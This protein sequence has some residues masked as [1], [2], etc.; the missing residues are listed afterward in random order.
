MKGCK[1]ATDIAVLQAAVYS[2]TSDTVLWQ[3]PNIPQLAGVKVFTQGLA[4]DSKKGA[5]VLTYRAYCA[6]IAPLNGWM[7][8]PGQCV[9]KSKYTG[10]LDGAMSPSFYLPVVQFSGVLN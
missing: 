10:Q 6:E 5:A 7:T 2:S 1:L 9:Y 3:I 4:M 8:G